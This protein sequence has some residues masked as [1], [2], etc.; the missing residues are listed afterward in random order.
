LTREITY[1]DHRAQQLKDQELAGKQPRGGLN[2]GK[3]R[4]RADDLEERLKRR[5]T[6]LDE[7]A[8]LSKLPP[9]VVGGAL[10]IPRGLLDRLKGV[11]D[12]EPNAHARETERVER[13]A[14]NAVLRAERALGRNPTEMARNNP[15]YDV[16][17]LTSDSDLL[18]IEVKGRVDGAKEFT[19]TRTEILTSLNKPEQFVLALVSVGADDATDVRYVRKPF[20][21]TDEMYFDM[22]SANYKWD[23]MFG[24]GS[25][26]A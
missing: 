15:G 22:T 19:I 17:S 5:L 1:W 7:K 25:V 2:S 16:K 18:F 9:V 14:V 3:A 20:K 21:G 4:T 26:P 23:E 10:V 13:L 6:E 11:R 24:R 12:V 8:Q